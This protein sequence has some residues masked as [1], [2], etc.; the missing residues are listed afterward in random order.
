VALYHHLGYREVQRHGY[1]L[2]DGTTLPVIRMEKT[3]VPT[4]AFNEWGA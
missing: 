3:L 2:P 1:T 4:A